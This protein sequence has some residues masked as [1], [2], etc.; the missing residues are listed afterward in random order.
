MQCPLLPPDTNTDTDTASDADFREY[1]AVEAVISHQHHPDNP[2]QNTSF[3]SATGCE[4]QVLTIPSKRN[5]KTDTETAEMVDSVVMEDTKC[6][7]T[8][9]SKV[10][11]SSRHGDG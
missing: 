1:S 7:V 3:R 8:Q 11:N 9:C 2:A 6:R 5:M 4:T 10:S